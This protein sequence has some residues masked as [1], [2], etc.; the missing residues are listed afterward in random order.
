MDID[1]LQSM[2]LQRVGYNWATEYALRN[3]SPES[4]SSVNEV[5]SAG[6]MAMILRLPHR[7]LV[8]TIGD[9]APA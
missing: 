4:E 2:G 5:S 7:V 8:V 6:G 1:G 9:I 3:C